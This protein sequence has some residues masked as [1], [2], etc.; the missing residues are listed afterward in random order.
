[1]NNVKVS[2][3]G[4]IKWNMNGI[5]YTQFVADKRLIEYAETN[6]KLTLNVIGTLSV[7]NFLGKVSYQVIV[8]EFEIIKV[9]DFKNKSNFIW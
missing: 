3:G 1:M 7:N 8:E 9:E 2:A 4:M 5:D 6:K